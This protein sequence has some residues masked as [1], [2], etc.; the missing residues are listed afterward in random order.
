MEFNRRVARLK[1]ISSL[2]YAAS[3]YFWKRKERRQQDHEVP[4]KHPTKLV[5]LLSNFMVKWVNATAV[6]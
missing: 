2:I 1:L 3:F 4:G 6:F 5:W